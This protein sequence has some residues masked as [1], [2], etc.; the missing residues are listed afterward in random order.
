MKFR[1][2]TIDE[3][4]AIKYTGSNLD[5]IEDFVNGKAKKTLVVLE[6]HGDHNGEEGVEILTPGGFIM[7]FVD[8]WIVRGPQGEIYRCK[9]KSFE[10][11][12][13]PVGSDNSK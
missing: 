12:Y 13:E 3:V 9:S 7:A 5:E 4:D 6:E 10:G 2:K 11:S 8:D 1:R